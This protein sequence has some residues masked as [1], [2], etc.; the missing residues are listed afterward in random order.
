M[1]AELKA[2]RAELTRI[3]ALLENVTEGG[4][5]MRTTAVS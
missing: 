3:T 5:A 4:N 1:V 2:L